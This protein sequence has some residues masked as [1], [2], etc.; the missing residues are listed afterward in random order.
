[1]LVKFR[2][3]MVIVITTWLGLFG[4]AAAEK[5]VTYRA[6]VVETPVEELRA[7]EHVPSS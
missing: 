5:P 7:H 1:M 3:A 2:Y 6:T 4:S